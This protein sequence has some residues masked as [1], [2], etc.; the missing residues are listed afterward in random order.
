MILAIEPEALTLLVFISSSDNEHFDDLA[1][2][3]PQVVS[4]VEIAY[5]FK[6]ANDSDTSSSKTKMVKFK[7]L[8]QKKTA[9]AANPLIVAAPPI[10][11]VPLPTV[12][13]ILELTMQS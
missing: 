2:A 3:P 13:T 5:S 10:S 6:E 4:E 7:T 11:Q 1:Y 12:N 8:G 9:L